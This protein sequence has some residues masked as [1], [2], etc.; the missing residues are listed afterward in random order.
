[1]AKYV[2]FILVILCQGFYSQMPPPLLPCLVTYSI[3]TQTVL[4][5]GVLNTVSSVPLVISLSSRSVEPTASKRWF[6]SWKLSVNFGTTK[7]PQKFH[8][9]LTEDTVLVF[10]ESISLPAPPIHFEHGR[11]R[12][13]LK[14]FNI[15]K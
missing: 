12:V 2:P 7:L 13:F 14:V 5:P 9:L 3:F 6:S 8:Y 11:Q 10:V 1:M 4:S 15:G